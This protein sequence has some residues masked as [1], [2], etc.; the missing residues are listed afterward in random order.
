MLGHCCYRW[1]HHRK[2]LWLHRWSLTMFDNSVKEETHSESLTTHEVESEEKRLR[3]LPQWRVN[4]CILLI[5]NYPSK[6][7]TCGYII[8]SLEG[9][10]FNLCCFSLIGFSILFIYACWFTKG[11]NQNTIKQQK[12]VMEWFKEKK[13]VGPVFHSAGPLNIN[14]CNVMISAER[15]NWLETIKLPTSVALT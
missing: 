15:G 7:W 8:I 12:N 4:T 10:F 13:T 11:M 5:T 9:F 6:I 1:K 14:S 3:Y 2:A